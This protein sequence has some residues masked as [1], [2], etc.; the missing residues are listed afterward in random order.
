[1]VS[2]PARISP[3]VATLTG[4]MMVLLP[5]RRRSRREASKLATDRLRF[6]HLLITQV[7]LFG[8]GSDIYTGWRWVIIQS[9]EGSSGGGLPWRPGDE[10]G[11]H[12]FRASF[13]RRYPTQQLSV[14]C[15]WSTPNRLSTFKPDACLQAP[16]C[17]PEASGQQRCSFSCSGASN[18]MVRCLAAWHARAERPR[19]G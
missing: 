17:R 9:F 14:P 19:D 4:G 18:V 8:Y 7:V 2:Q 10:P 5:C 12:N 16:G 15:P 1:M 3:W 13:R 6:P 11:R